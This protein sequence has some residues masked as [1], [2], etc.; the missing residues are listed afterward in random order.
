MRPLSN[1]ILGWLLLAILCWVPLP[2]GS[3]R[4]LFWALNAGAVALLGLV[5]GASWLLSGK[6][7]RIT[8]R[9]LGMLPWAFAAL[10]VY[11]C[12]QIFVVS[13]TPPDTFLMV[14]RILTYGIFFF[15][16]VQATHNPDRA[17][18]ILDL[19]LI[20]LTAYAVLALV[21]LRN[22]D[23]ILGLEKTAYLGSA[24]GTFI[25]RNSFAT[26]LAFGCVL[27]FAKLLQDL[28][29]ELSKH[30][31][32]RHPWLNV[33]LDA[34]ALVALSATLVATQSRM[35]VGA[36]IIGLVVI[37][38]LSLPK[39][40][41]LQAKAVLAMAAVAGIVA[42]VVALNSSVLLQRLVFTEQSWVE[43]MELYR[44]VVE[45]IGMRPITG[46]GGGSFGMAFQQVHHPP[47]GID[48]TWD[49]AHNSYLTLLAELGLIAG[50]IVPL[51]VAAITWRLLAAWRTASWNLP[52]KVALG[53][54]AV[55]A[56]HAIVD[57]SLEIQGVAM[58]FL[59]FIA[60][61]TAQT[62]YLASMPPDL[63][64]D[65]EAD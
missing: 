58:W 11:L 64:S 55:A 10:C 12:V 38:L 28:D 40:M 48:R 26:L 8:L 14:V 1:S 46:S 59:A 22:G 24:T 34:L 51:I 56:S 23:T 45:L 9:D 13:V 35:G 17:G 18:R 50:L 21:L 4:P 52:V 53:V 25:N 37:A 41:K 43:R 49:K 42:V 30:E 36:A 3:N 19:A 60:C 44:Q 7:L 39:S 57:F 15:L 16:V 20:A 61:G 47:L 54:I 33:A 2:L 5:Y 31:E 27:A 32:L 29:S 6:R 62:L 65:D 63:A